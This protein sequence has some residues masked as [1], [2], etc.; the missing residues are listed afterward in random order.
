MM[1]RLHSAR[2]RL[3]AW[4]AVTLALVL[5]VSGGLLYGVVAYQLVRH[6]D[7]SLKEAAARVAQI[8]SEHEVCEILTPSQRQGLDGVGHLVLFH[9]V[10]GERRVFFRSTDLDLMQAPFGMFASA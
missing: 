4:Y 1:G 6:H 5:S 2:S 10:A 3:T 7:S 9:E 8:L